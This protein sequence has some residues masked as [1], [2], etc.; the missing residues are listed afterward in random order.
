M[1]INEKIKELRKSRG[2]SQSKLGSLL[3]PPVTYQT[4]QQIESGALTPSFE[5]IEDIARAFNTENIYF[6]ECG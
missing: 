4:I 2:W 1:K 6:Q 3:T 5:R